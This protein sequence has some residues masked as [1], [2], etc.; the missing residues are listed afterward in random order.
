MI[1]LARNTEF[2]DS[3]TRSFYLN[4]STLNKKIPLSSTRDETSILDIMYVFIYNYRK[5]STWVHLC[6][7]NAFSTAAELLIAIPGLPPASGINNIL[8]DAG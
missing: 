1:T 2:Q 8:N 5:V 3:C 7:D 4:I 6:M